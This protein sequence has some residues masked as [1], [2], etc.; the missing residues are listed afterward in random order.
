MTGVNTVNDWMN[1]LAEALR[2]GD[3]D[4]INKLGEMSY[5]WLQ[6]SDERAA[7]INLCEAALDALD[8]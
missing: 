7:Q 8:Y 6:P 4:K 1:E 5:Q 2:E 3:I